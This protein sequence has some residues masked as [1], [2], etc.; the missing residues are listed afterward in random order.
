[1]EQKAVNKTAFHLA[2]IIPVAGHKKDFGFEWD[3][4]L[5]PIAENYTAIERSVMECAYA[6][7]ETIWIVCN[8]DIQPLLRHRIGRWYKTQSGMGGFWQ[9]TQKNIE[10]KYQ[11]TIYQST[12]RTETEL[13]VMLGAF[14]TERIRLIGLVNK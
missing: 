12:Q 10:N 3:N 14:Y 9:H 13:I 1:M 6:G 5:M 11:Y 8:N 2:G 7:C 4:V